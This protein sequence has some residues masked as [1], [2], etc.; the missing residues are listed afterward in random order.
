MATT[1][2]NYNTTLYSKPQTFPLTGPTKHSVQVW[3]AANRSLGWDQ[4]FTIATPLWD[5]EQLGTLRTSKGFDK[6]DL[7]GIS[8]I[9][10]LWKKGEV[11]TF[12]FLKQEFHLAS[13]VFPIFAGAPCAQV[14]STEGCLSPR[15]LAAGRWIA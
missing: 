12:A 10:D 6:W 1:G 3:H 15:I 9:D 8:K 4:I 2:G 14:M 11:V 7:I 13:R 5:T